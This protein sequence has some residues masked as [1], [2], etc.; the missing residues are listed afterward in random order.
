[1]AAVTRA[2]LLDRL[3]VVV[4]D[5]SARDRAER[6]RR[7]RSAFG[8]AKGAAVPPDFVT[9]RQLVDYQITVKTD[10]YRA[11]QIRAAVVPVLLEYLA[12]ADVAKILTEANAAA[13]ALEGNAA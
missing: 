4:A 6:E 7:V 3:R 8:L 9:S 12:D 10:E 2:E 13:R 5:V 11:E 1:M